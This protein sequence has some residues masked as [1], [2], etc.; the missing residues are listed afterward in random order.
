VWGI[1]PDKSA[2][3]TMA[4]YFVAAGLRQDIIAALREF[5]V[6]SYKENKNASF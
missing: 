3:N 1:E 6:G 4:K 2:L 5:N